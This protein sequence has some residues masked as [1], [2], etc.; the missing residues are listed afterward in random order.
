MIKRVEKTVCV[1]KALPEAAMFV[2]TRI[3]VLW[4]KFSIKMKI[5]ESQNLFGGGGVELFSQALVYVNR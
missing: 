2:N 1:N 5:L 3:I 4:G